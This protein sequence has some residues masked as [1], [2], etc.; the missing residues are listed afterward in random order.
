MENVVYQKYARYDFN[1]HE[2]SKNVKK[3]VDISL[4]N[5]N[6]KIN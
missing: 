3:V 2:V 5:K 4:T 6:T 1:F